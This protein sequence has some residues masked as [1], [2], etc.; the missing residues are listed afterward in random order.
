ME[1]LI[2]TPLKPSELIMGKTIPYIIIAE[3]QMVMVTALAVAWFHVPL[4][5][6]VALLFL[7]TCLF[8]LSTLGI[9]LVISTVSAT[10][11]Q[12]VMTTFFFAMPFFM[13]SGFV[14]PIANMPT[15]V[16][17]FTYLNPLRY[18]LVIIRGIFLKGV[19]L[20]ILWP[21]FLAMTILGIVFFTGSVN[22][23][24]KRLD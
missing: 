16:Q 3:S 20:K 13:L 4:K 24:K 21:Q 1:Q 22:R 10:K 12:A 11:Q 23:F 8:L 19:G 6:N 18:L 17:W 7:A 5:G 9:G 15:V 14:F 2:V